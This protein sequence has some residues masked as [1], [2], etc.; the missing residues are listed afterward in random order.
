MAEIRRTPVEVGR[1]YGYPIIYEVLYIPGGCL[2][3]LPST[4]VWAD[5]T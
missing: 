2:G 1:L 5:Q 3:F 4:V